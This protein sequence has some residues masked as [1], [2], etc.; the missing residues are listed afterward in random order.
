MSGTG[1]RGSF[2]ELDEGSDEGATPALSGGGSSGAFWAYWT[3]EA[4]AGLT[5]VSAATGA[6][7]APLPAETAAGGGVG[8]AAPQ[9]QPQ[10]PLGAGL[11]PVGAAAGEVPRGARDDEQL[12]PALQRA[13]AAEASGAAPASRAS[14]LPQATRRGG[15]AT[16]SG[17]G[18]RA[19][20]SELRASRQLHAPAAV[21]PPVTVLPPRPQQMVPVQRSA[22]SLTD[23]FARAA[24]IEGQGQAPL[25]PT[26]APAHHWDSLEDADRARLA[27]AIAALP[28]RPFD[29][30]PPRTPAVRGAEVELT[31]SPQTVRF[32]SA[33]LIDD[34]DATT[35]APPVGPE[36]ASENL[37]PN[38]MTI[39]AARGE[40]I[41]R[42]L[43][44][45]ISGGRGASSR[46]PLTLP[47]A[48]AAFV[49]ED[50][51]QAAAR[52]ADAGGRD[53]RLG[54][55]HAD[56]AKVEAALQ[57]LELLT[58]AVRHKLPGESA[59]LPAHMDASL[60]GAHAALGDLLES[61]QEDEARRGESDADAEALGRLVRKRAGLRV[62][63]RMRQQNRGVHAALPQAHH[64]ATVTTSSRQDMAAY[65]RRLGLQRTASQVNLLEADTSDSVANGG[66]TAG[67]APL[68]GRPS[69]FSQPAR[70][71]FGERALRCWTHRYAVRLR[72][73]ALAGICI[74]MLVIF[75][76]LKDRLPVYSAL[77]HTYGITPE[78]PYLYV[79]NESPLTWIEVHL[80]VPSTDETALIH[81][82]DNTPHGS[83]KAAMPTLSAA[84]FPPEGRAGGSSSSDIEPRNVTVVLQQSRL[85]ESGN[86][87]ESVVEIV[88]LTDPADNTFTTDDKAKTYVLTW[89][90]VKSF[91][92]WKDGYPLELNVSVS[93][94]GEAVACEIHPLQLGWIGPAQVWLGLTV[95]IVILGIIASELLHRTLAAIVGSFVVLGLLM[96][97]NKAP[98]MATVVTWIDAAALSLLFGM[99]VLVGVLAE[100]GAFEV[101]AFSVLRMARGKSYRLLVLLASVTALLSAFLDNVTTILLIVP[102][103]IQICATLNVDAFPYLM[104]E[105]LMSNIGGAA[106]LIGDPPNIIIGNALPELS[107]T[108]FLIYMAPGVLLISPFVLLSF[109]LLF[110]GWGIGQDLLE[111]NNLLR[112]RDQFRITN[113]HLFMQC[114]IVLGFVV[115]GFLLHPL[116]HIDP[117]WIA[118]IGATLLLLVSTPSDIDGALE[119]VEWQTLLF[120]AALFVMMEGL[121]E[122]GV[123]RIIADLFEDI[124][125]SVPEDKR[126]IVAI[127]IL[128][129]GSAIISA[130][131]D[132]IPFTVAMV[133]VVD[134]IVATVPGLTIE[135]LGFSL[136][137][138]ADLGGN[139]S[140]VGASAN[141][142]MAGLAEKHQHHISFFSFLKYGFPTMILSVAIATGYLLLVFEAIVK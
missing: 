79:F 95:L 37:T 119:A 71:A 45:A 98:S 100:T 26:G 1:H 60:N 47:A 116:H 99:M 17:T 137:F 25:P 3:P 62:G 12:R 126:Q 94:N 82:A 83:A 51:P 112:L 118:L 138:G 80:T 42:E 22:S 46:R 103:T 50:E 104:A 124:I 135:A 38:N 24:E 70:S 27:T 31:A 86:G 74:A 53:G 133:Q 81:G 54:R 115:L 35:A 7:A 111:Y 69:F 4:E 123:I 122:L 117:A 127:V 43:R 120:F 33:T 23:L 29:I 73:L 76:F 65:G 63:L 139:G 72:L 89:S 92:G 61:F 88:T 84:L 108:D 55:Q 130:F 109:R 21:A 68:Q 134:Q 113:W 39:S 142:V 132:N 57:E 34:G 13:S 41:A 8:G 77:E 32:G 6:V 48:A 56:V 67:T 20:A 101:A 9:P 44:R 66:E 125:L 18:G 87:S 140:L 110:R 19:M 49:D 11:A 75:P 105:T 129:W 36:P 58:D 136:A 97:A 121:A 14:Q 2:T 93:A 64:Y 102:V 15:G 141:I 106:T 91:G 85:T 30:S 114:M 10:P 128:V 107:F 131:L 90:N 28:G 96:L 52:G 59:A 78:L 5:P 16:V 40:D